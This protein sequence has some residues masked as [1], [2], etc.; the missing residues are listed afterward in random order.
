MQN[1]SAG[2]WMAQAGMTSAWDFKNKKFVMVKRD[3]NA[4]KDGY[5]QDEKTPGTWVLQTKSN[6]V[7]NQTTFA[8]EA[9]AK[10]NL[11]STSEVRWTYDAMANVGYW[12]QVASVRGAQNNPITFSPAGPNSNMIDPEVEEVNK[13]EYFKLPVGAWVYSVVK[14]GNKYK[15]SFGAYNP[16]YGQAGANLH[17]KGK[18]LKATDA[19]TEKMNYQITYDNGTGYEGGNDPMISA[20]MP[21]T[22]FAYGGVVPQR[23]ELGGGIFGTDTVPAMLTPGEFV[24][25]KS[26]VDAIGV[27]NLKA[28]NSGASMGDCVYNYSVTVNANSS[29][30][31]GIA[32]AV[33]REIKRIDS[34]RI[35][36]SVVNG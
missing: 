22:Q 5:V 1:G 24:V 16:K 9:E 30:A 3:A 26:A 33:M 8:T 7:N 15:I 20:Y 25:K 2:G 36:S 10:K 23:F 34:Q 32:D 27:D 14:N 29:D 21:K 35:R 4:N 18:T 12:E 6:N 13:G 17:S 19:I 31:S 11:P 28:M